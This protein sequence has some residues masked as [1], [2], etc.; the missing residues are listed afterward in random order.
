MIIDCFT[1]FNELKLLQLRLEET[2]DVVDYYVLVESIKT[3][4]N[5]DKELYYQNNKHLFEK[6]RHKIIHIIVDDMP[7]ESD[8]TDF[9]IIGN[10]PNDAN[11]T[12]ERF[13]RNAIMRGLQR[14]NLNGDDIIIIND[15]DEIIRKE[16][17]EYFKGD[18]VRGLYVLA[19]DSYIYNLRNKCLQG[20][21]PPRISCGSR[22]INYGD[23]LEIGSVDKVRNTYL[24]NRELYPNGAINDNL[25]AWIVR[26]AGWHFSYFGETQSIIDKIKSY[27]HQELNTKDIINNIDEYIS[28]GKYISND[29]QT[30]IVDIQN[31]FNLPKNYGIIL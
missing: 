18:G 6:Y 17:L 31:N 23:L 14:L 29:Y 8:S 22:A 3:F 10:H 28:S 21:P 19:V 16:V 24:H 9:D 13:Q 27:S 26:D 4:T 15:A 7:E 11:W 2:S 12:R 5:K 20:W 25:F 30:E 1:F